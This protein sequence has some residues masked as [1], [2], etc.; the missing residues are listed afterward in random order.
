MLG[1]GVN[2]HEKKID[3]T[4]I[5]YNTLYNMSRNLRPNQANKNK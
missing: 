4:N 3:K 5:N 1:N 2:R